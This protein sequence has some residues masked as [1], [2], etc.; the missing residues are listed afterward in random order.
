MTQTSTQEGEEDNWV[1]QVAGVIWKPHSPQH[2]DAMTP[3]LFCP[4]VAMDK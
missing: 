4:V 3:D 2:L 1:S